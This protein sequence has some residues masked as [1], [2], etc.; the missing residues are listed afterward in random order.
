VKYF[1]QVIDINKQYLASYLALASIAEK[2]KDNQQAENYLLTA[3]HNNND[4]TVQLKILSLLGKWYAKFKQ[5]EKVLTL[6]EDLIK[7]HPEEIPAMSFLAGAQLINQQDKA[8]EKT[9]SEIVSNSDKD[10]KHRILTAGF[11]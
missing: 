3:Y 9:L 11:E 6:A 5:P 4:L 7:Q 1:K 8:A 10:K 2:N